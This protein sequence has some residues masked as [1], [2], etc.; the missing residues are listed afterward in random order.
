V[1]DS[2]IQKNPATRFPRV[3]C[4]AEEA[5]A[6]QHSVMVTGY[7]SPE[8]SRLKDRYFDLG[9]IHQG[10]PQPSWTVECEDGT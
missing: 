2:E 6:A 5:G 1:T 3:Q 8:M 4:A 7:A 9:I 10:Y